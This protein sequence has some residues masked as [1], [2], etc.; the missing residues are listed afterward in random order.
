[1]RNLVLVG[2]VTAAA[3]CTNITMTAPALAWDDCGR[4]Y[5]YYTPRAYSYAP[6]PWLYRAYD[7]PAFFYGNAFYRPRVW[8]WRSWDGGRRW[9]WRG[10]WSG[11]RW[12]WGGRHWGRRW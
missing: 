10:G 1:M 5:G 12:G 4:S 7:R 6:S 11:R 8:G 2:L 9:G 3:I